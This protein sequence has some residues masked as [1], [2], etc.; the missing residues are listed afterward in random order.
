MKRKKEKVKKTIA[1]IL[2]LL[3]MLSAL[4]ACGGQDIA[5]GET[6]LLWENATYKEDAAIGEGA[7]TVTV[8]IEA[9]EKKITLTVSTNAENLGEALYACSLINDPSFFD[10][11]NGIKADYSENQSWWAF[12]IGEEMAPYGVDSE[13]IENGNSYRLVYTR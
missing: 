4:T 8:S 11:A 5:P 2:A 1:I 3:A 6:E 10:T 12:Y 13:I 7:K 9:L